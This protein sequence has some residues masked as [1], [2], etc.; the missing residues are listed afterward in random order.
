MSQRGRSGSAGARRADGGDAANSSPGPDLGPYIKDLQEM[1]RQR[2]PGAYRAFIAR[3]RDLHQPGAAGRLLAMDDSALRL[4]IERMILDA[5][6]L[7]DLHAAAR[8]YLEAHHALPPSREGAPPASRTRG[9]P[10]PGKIRLRQR[11]HDA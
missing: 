4:R 2:S 6:G 9:A 5:P 8:E 11:P 10:A 3:W 1:L 7:A